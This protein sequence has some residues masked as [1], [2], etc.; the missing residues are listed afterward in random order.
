MDIPCFIYVLPVEPAQKIFE[1]VKID[2]AAAETIGAPIG[3]TS[4]RNFS[5]GLT[6]GDILAQARTGATD[7][8]L[9]T[10]RYVSLCNDTQA[11]AAPMLPVDLLSR[12]SPSSSD[13]KKGF[14]S[15]KKKK[16]KQ[17]P[18]MLMAVPEGSTADVVRQIHS[19]LMQNPRM[20]RWW[21]QQDPFDSSWPVA[22]PTEQKRTVVV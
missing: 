17:I 3:S 9:A 5:E 13:K 19:R 1:V 16:K 21:K 12:Q 20:Q 18:E 10:Q 6:V 22:S 15:D 8:A 2:P 14:F 7:P 4:T 11:L